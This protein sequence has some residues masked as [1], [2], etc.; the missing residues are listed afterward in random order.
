VDDSVAFGLVLFLAFVVESAVGFGS[1]LVAISLGGQVLPLKQLFPI[2]QPLSLVLS[3]TL[4][5]RGWHQIDR[6]FLLRAAFPAMA[7][8]CLI[9]MALFRLGPAD[10]LLFGVGTA[11]AG[12]ALFELV[13]TLRGQAATPLPTS[14]SRAVLFVAGII[15]GLFGAS[16]PPVVWVASRS[17]DD[18]SRFRATL[19][20]LWA[21]LSLALIVGYVVDGSLNLA[22]LRQSALLA[23]PLLAGFFVG[24]LVHHKVPQRAFRLA[25]CVLL[26]LAGSALMV[27]AL[28]AFLAVLG[29]G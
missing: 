15:H 8:G 23:L 29:G 13:R 20:L 7:P 17:I 4:V 11:I 26:I 25:V 19:A 14:T 16:G 3:T 27:R 9:G 1:A 5:V 24:N 2:F 21:V 18:K 12:L 6:A 28:P 22:T 10:A